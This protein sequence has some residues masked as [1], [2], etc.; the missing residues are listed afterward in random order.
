T[1][2]LMSL[3]GQYGGPGLIELDAILT[4]Q[5]DFATRIKNLASNLV[6]DTWWRWKFAGRKDIRPHEAMAALREWANTKKRPSVRAKITAQENHLR[7]LLPRTIR[8]ETVLSDNTTLRRQALN[9]R[10]VKLHR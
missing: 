3:R 7:L 8:R 5:P 10:L 6:G 4:H 2:L 1:G 9:R